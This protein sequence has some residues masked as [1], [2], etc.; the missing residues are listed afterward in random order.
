MAKSEKSNDLEIELNL[1]P[2]LFLC[3]GLLFLCALSPAQ[4][5]EKG[6][7]VHALSLHGTPVYGPDFNH[8]NYVNP[9]APKQ[10]LIRLSDF[11]TYDSFNPFIVKGTPAAGMGYLQDSL[12]FAT[13]MI[14][15][16]DEPFTLYCYAAETVEVAPDNTWVEFKLRPNITF[17]DGS[18]I[19][20]DDIVWGFKQMMEKGTPAYKAYYGDV[21]EVKKKDHLTVRFTFK[22]GDNR[23]LPMIL[24]ELPVISKKYYS[25]HGFTTTKLNPP[26]GSGPYKI[27]SF[28]AGHNI[29]YSLVE[30]WWGASLPPC[31]GRYNFE[32]IRYDYYRD[33]TVIFEAFK[34]GELDFH[35]ERIAKNWVTGYDIAAV[36]QGKMLRTVI[37]ERKSGMMQGIIMNTRLPLFEDRRIRAALS[38]AFDFEWANEN[39]FHNLY[40]RCTSYFSGTELASS[41]LPSD[42]ELEL[43]EPFR[44]Q[45]PPELF[46]SEFIPPKTDGSGNIRPQLRQAKKLLNAAGCKVVDGKLIHP[47]TG[48]PFEFEILIVQPGIER[49]LQNFVKNLK[50]LG[51][52]VNLRMVDTSQ[53]IARVEEFDF[54]MITLV[55]PQS[56]SP[57]NEQ[58][59]FWQSDRIQVK[60]SRNFAG[61]KDLVVDHL[62]EKL[63][64]A[65]SREDLVNITRAL[66]RVLLWGHYVIPM[67]YSGD[68]RLAYWS[69]LKT[70][71][72]H[73]QYSYDIHSWWFAE[74]AKG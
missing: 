74:E 54:E 2:R 15:S 52:T 44:D 68:K 28:D 72:N 58:R 40:N 57:G 45:L 37:P 56:I 62:I 38:Y 11:G 27:N 69:H 39:L 47:K 6:K 59:E 53:Y 25:K 7:P 32:K 29:E 23:E 13:L 65:D 67:Y 42:E 70:P 55:L 24:G 43:L 1:I 3:L 21:K 66:D 51:V 61:I 16:P 12:L 33:T 73:P 10:G 48:K 64:D 20:A 18:P 35:S 49:V 50:L 5:I 14:H 9:H 8:F 4:S 17:H 71:E 41:G 22:D 46:S 60:G 26:V 19:T 30:N 31:I 63:I 36:K 34:A